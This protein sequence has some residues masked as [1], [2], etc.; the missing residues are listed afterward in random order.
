[1]GKD[2]FK[3]AAIAGLGATGLGL[4]GVGPMAGMFGAEAAGAGLIPGIGAAATMGAGPLAGTAAGG[5]LAPAGAAATMGAGLGGAA[6]E[7][8][9]TG[10]L[11]GGLAGFAPKAA[12]G[13]MAG[14]GPMDFMRMGSMGNNM[15]GQKPQ[16]PGMAPP[17]IPPMGQM[18]GAQQAPY[19]GMSPYALPGGLN[20]HSM[21]TARMM[22]PYG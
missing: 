17:M 10:G 21:N 9:A 18:G 13:M 14:M 6:A 12:S 1:M 3:I 19:A 22:N 20:L 11:T 7:G 2:T 15:M 16:Q 8:L 4:A 5:L